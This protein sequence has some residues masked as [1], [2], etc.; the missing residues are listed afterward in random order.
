LCPDAP[1]ELVTLVGAM[2]AHSPLDRPASAAHVAEHLA[3][4]TQAADLV[5]LLK[6]ARETES[7]SPQFPEKS[8][9]SETP[10]FTAASGPFAEAGSGQGNHRRPRRWVM[11]AMAIP[12][13][14]LAGILIRLETNKGQLVI[15]SEVDNIKVRINSNGR[16]VSGL[17]IKQGA[18][19]TRL[20]ADKYEIVIDGPSDGLTIDNN[21][22]TLSNGDT[23][24]ARIRTDAVTDLHSLPFVDGARPGAMGARPDNEP[25]YEGQTLSEWLEML[26]RERSAAGLKS[27]FDACS[28]LASPATSDRITQTLL[29]VVPGLEGE[30]N[31][32]PDRQDNSSST[33]DQ[34]AMKVL[35]KAN[36]GPAYYRLWVRQF[37]MADENWRKRLWNYALFGR[38]S[39]S[40]VEPFVT[41]A[42]LRL[43]QEPTGKM[44]FDKDTEKAADYLRNLTSGVPEDPLFMERVSAALSNS[45]HLGTT[46]WLSQPLLHRSGETITSHG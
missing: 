8:G 24:V 37:E 4:F 16:P 9:G 42:E 2:L 13:M 33:L 27:A 39:V 44:A 45:P 17:S 1:E 14:I 19:A 34:E 30:Q 41:W 40:T 28:A 26:A 21:Q 29:S 31:L 35:Y 36:P 22:F 10:G 18:T 11:A 20:R 25:L 15:E 32:T 46:W 7:Q 6:R 38:D 5:G 12:L 43:S 3:A 23:I